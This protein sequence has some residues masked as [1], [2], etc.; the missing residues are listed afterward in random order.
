VRRERALTQEG[1]AELLGVSRKTID[2]YERRATNPSADVLENV[3]KKLAVSV[4][5]LLGHEELPPKRAPKAHPGPISALEQ[6]IEKLRRLPRAQ[7][8]VVVKMLDGLLQ[9]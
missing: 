9:S 8:E 4:A 6:R 5:F 1:L 2:Y 3:A 7:Q